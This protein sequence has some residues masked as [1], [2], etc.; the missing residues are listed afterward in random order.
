MANFTHLHVHTQYSILDGAANI[1][2]VLERVKELGMDSLA[3]TDHGNMYG[4][5]EFFNTAKKVGIKPILGC[6][7]YVAEDR[8]N[9]TGPESR[10]GY[11][12]ILLAKNEIGYNNLIKLCSLGFLKENYYYTPRIDK[13]LLRQ[14]SEGLIC[15]SACLGGELPQ[16]IMNKNIDAASLV[17]E[18]FKELFGEDYYLEMQNHGH[19]DQKLVNAALIELSKKHGVKLIATNDIHF[20]NKEDKDAHHILLCVN[21]GRKFDDETSMGYTGEEY[22]KSEEEMLALFAECPEAIT[23]TQ[24]IVNKIEHFELERNIILPK[25]PLPDGFDEMQY[26]T[27]ITWEGAAKRYPVMTDEIKERIQFELDTIEKMGFPG[28]FLIVQDFINVSRNELGVI[29]GPGRGSAAGSVIAYC[30]GITNIDPVKYKL[31]FERF[32]NPERISM[33]DIDVDFDDEGR[34]KALQYVMDK[35]GADHVAQIVTFGA[36]AAKSAIKDVARVMDLDLPT[37]NML[38]KLV[39]EKPGTTLK[40]AFEEVP[41]LREYRDNGPEL[42]KKVLKYAVQLEGSIRN[43]GVHACGV[44]IGPQDIS[45]FVPVASAKD[46]DLMVTQF[47]GKLIESVGML[48]MDFLGLKTLSIIKTACQ[49]IKKRHGVEL[50]MDNIPLNDELTYKLYQNGATVGTFQFESEGMQSHLRDLKP[51]RFEDLIAMNALYRPGP[52]Q[53]IPQ[54]IARKHGKE[55]IE[56]DI[57]MMSEYLDETYGIT[58]Y[59]EQVMLLSQS[60]AGFTKGQADG[61][62]KAMG[63]K[64]KD[65]MAELKTKFVDGCRKKE[66]PDDKVEKVWCD[67]EKF[68]EYAF[69]KSHATCYSFVAYQ[70]GYLKAHYPAEYMSAVLTHNLSDIKKITFFIDECRRLK[71]PVLGPDVNESDIHFMVNDKGEIRFGLGAIKGMGENAAAEL[72]AERE[73]NGKFTSIFDF[74]E[75]V[76]LKSINSKNLESLAKSGSFDTFSDIHRAQYFYKKDTDSTNFIGRLIR[77]VN[78]KNSGDAAQVSLFDTCETLKQEEYPAIPEAE[79]WSNNEQANN[80]K[81]VIGFF[82]SGHPL[83]DYKAEIKC[84]TNTR[85]SELED[86]STLKTRQDIKFAG[87][88]TACSSGMTKTN[89]PFGKFTIEDYDGSYSIALFSDDYVK[90]RN[91]LQNDMFVFCKATV[92]EKAWKREGEVE[93]LELKIVDMILLESVMDKFTKSIVIHVKLGDITEDFCARMEKIIKQNKGKVTL[94]SLVRDDIN[95]VELRMISDKKV[96]PHGF[97]KSIRGMEEIRSFEIH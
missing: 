50:D 23:N 53:Y 64:L 87:I 57:P 17:V 29:I 31:L 40:K 7:M 47:E 34:E 73:A 55:K 82:M 5:L 72:I 52:M 60:M 54:F 81:E 67:W 14:Y 51:T 2:A 42:V 6:E 27:H 4:V 95:N 49:N 15:C 41:E 1:K 8:H 59:Q 35:Y 25:F 19:E 24:E 13:E 33:P 76:N 48:K 37:S 63:K 56:Y 45:N 18:E 62:R 96:D 94:S 30:I 68:A 46:S 39:P 79:R 77:W 80:E 11:H 85:V 44:I 58:V 91:F 97:I 12:L 26:L 21:T 66:L 61:L 84:F 16:T 74:F 75:R 86:L 28:Y 36:M 3:I 22:V 70:T 38:A 65:K 32:L 9:K 20:V 83:D 43:T 90:Y 78:N 10:S 89:K 93:A 71:I 92:K 88:I 69:N